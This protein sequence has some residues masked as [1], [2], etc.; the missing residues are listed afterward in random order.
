MSRSEGRQVL[1]PN[2]EIVLGLN[3]RKMHLFDAKTTRVVYF[4]V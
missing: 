3:L 1:R 2:E 4:L